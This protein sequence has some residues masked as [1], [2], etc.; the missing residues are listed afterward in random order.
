M[1]ASIYI[2]SGCDT[3]TVAGVH[4]LPTPR[5]EAASKVQLTFFLCAELKSEQ[6]E[7]KMHPACFLGAW[8][9]PSPSPDCFWPWNLLPQVDTINN[10][11]FS[12]GNF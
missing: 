6:T 3:D 11:L 12:I 5:Q 10:V 1:I 4:C 7:I 8:D 2:P 9:G